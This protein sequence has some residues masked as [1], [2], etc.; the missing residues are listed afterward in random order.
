MRNAS[1]L[2]A[3]FLWTQLASHQGR[4]RWL[5]G[6]F[7]LSISVM[8]WYALIQH[9]H[10]SRL[11][12]FHERPPQY[13]MRA[14]GAYFCP[15][16]FANLICIILPVCLALVTCQQAGIPLR[17]L[18]GY[19]LLLSLPVLLLTQSRSGWLGAVGGL[20]VVVCLKAWRK[21]T[22]RFLVVAVAAPLMAAGGA[23]AVWLVSPMVQARVADAL[24][25]NVRLNLWK[26][27]LDL[28]QTQPWFGYG[29]GSYKW[30]YPHFRHHLLD[31]LNPEFAHNEFLHLL[32][33]TGVAGFSLLALAILFFC[34][35][36][37]PFLRGA[38][39]DK[40]ASL[41]AGAAGSLAACLIH[42]G[43]DYNLQLYANA[44]SL[45]AVCGITAACLF[46]ASDLKGK[47]LRPVY[48]WSLA[49][50]GAL[51]LGGVSLL[52]FR[53]LIA[54]N[55]TL[56]ADQARAEVRYEAAV[57]GYEKALRVD[58]SYSPAWL[59]LG[60]TYR[61][62]SFWNLDAT[63]KAEQAA[64]ALQGFDR[65]VETNPWNVD[66]LYGKSRVLIAQGR[67]VEGIQVLRDIVDS[68]AHHPFYL[69]ELGLR[70][71]QTGRYEEALALFEQAQR[72]KP[73]EMA[74]INIRLLKA[75]LAESA[76]P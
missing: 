38:S 10:D 61:L 43:F 31:Y 57:Q 48:A 30:V 18:S 73:S 59:G 12:L 52:A 67:M 23:V 26:D 62:Q 29:P 17:L 37:F 9:G 56:A 44:Q 63:A 35:R 70:L 34:V 42:A 69:C 14:S 20:L 1:Y 54:R 68:V 16:H 58:A 75:K 25:G 8:D 32:A 66:A 45:I 21:G 76:A 22:W 3:F 74:A 40:D 53:S 47:V 50:A 24:K 19:T 7:M 51:L 60:E 65:A 64:A 33:E 2:A 72:V 41:V 13:E 27:T 36:L 15:N 71:R 11:V 46:A 6:I 4:W 28:I 5:L 39:R 49:L 55:V